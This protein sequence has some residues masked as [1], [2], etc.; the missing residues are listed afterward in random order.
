MESWNS[1]AES[2]ILCYNEYSTTLLNYFSEE[3]SI[4]NINKANW[5]Y[6]DDK[7]SL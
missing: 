1:A 2:F 6:F 4:K 7:I 3:F 5:S